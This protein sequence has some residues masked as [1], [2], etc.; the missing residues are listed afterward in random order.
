MAIYPPSIGFYGKGSSV[1]GEVDG[2]S[3]GKAGAKKK[4]SDANDDTLI[5]AIATAHGACVCCWEPISGDLLRML[6]AR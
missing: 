3:E 2:D 5:S 1:N 6:E 4:S